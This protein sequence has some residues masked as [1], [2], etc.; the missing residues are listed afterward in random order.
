MF[1]CFKV[2]FNAF[3]VIATTLGVV[4]ANPEMLTGG[5]I[6][7][8]LTIRRRGAMAA[9]QLLPIVFV[10]LIAASASASPIT[11]SGDLS[12]ASLGIRFDGDIGWTDLSLVAPETGIQ[13]DV[14]PAALTLNYDLVQFQTAASTFTFSE[15]LSSGFGSSSQYTI[16]LVFSPM[17][18]A[19]ASADTNVLS[20]ESGGSYAV[21]GDATPANAGAGLAS[22]SLVEPV[23][24]NANFIDGY[25]T[26]TG[27]ETTVS[28]TFNLPLGNPWTDSLTEATLNTNGYPGSL[29]L[30]FPNNDGELME[31]QMPETF[32][33]TTVDRALINVS[34]NVIVPGAGSDSLTQGSLGASA[35]E[36]STG[37]TMLGIA[38]LFLGIGRLRKRQRA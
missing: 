6:P 12:S 14:D 33:N 19:F 35:P 36:P 8:K 25:Y 5:K 24:A 38:V 34:S 3:N 20:P 26:V 27:P 1:A 30:T 11:Y 2:P 7:A 15:N 23:D 13:I 16:T 37:A 4:S 29:E 18:I 31:F 21:I 10:A 28:G 32:I 17:T 22:R 9:L